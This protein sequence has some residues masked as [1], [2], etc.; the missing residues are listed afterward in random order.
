MCNLFESAECYPR[1]TEQLTTEIVRVLSGEH[2]FFDA[3]V[4]HEL[5]TQHARLVGDI[6]SSV[7]DV[8]TVACRL[9]NGVLF[10]M[11]AAAQ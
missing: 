7:L 8:H 3:G 6:Y 4:D 10:G 1:L 2:D 9:S 11:D 5:R